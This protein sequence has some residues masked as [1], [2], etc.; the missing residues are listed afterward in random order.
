MIGKS[1]IATIIVIE[2]K[3]NKAKKSSNNFLNNFILLSLRNP[4]FKAG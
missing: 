2:T 3:T 1:K 4:P